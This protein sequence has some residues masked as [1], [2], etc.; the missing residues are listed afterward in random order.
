MGHEE[1]KELLAL[2]AAGALDEG[3]R[4]RLGAHIS[5]CAECR[6]EL[7]ELSDAAASLAYTVAPVAPRAGVRARV[8]ASVHGVEPSNAAS[9]SASLS[10]LRCGRAGGPIREKA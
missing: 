10:D 7:R 5:S 3:E 4:E 2:E 6:A 1:Y 9:P 8:L